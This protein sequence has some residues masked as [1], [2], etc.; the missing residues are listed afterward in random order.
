MAEPISL[1]RLA[2]I[3]MVAAPVAGVVWETTLSVERVSAASGR[4]LNTSTWWAL[5]TEGGWEDA[6][7]APALRGGDWVLVDRWNLFHAAG[8]AQKSTPRGS[9][10][11]FHSPAQREGSLLTARVGAF[12]GEWTRYGVVPRG[13][14]MVTQGVSVARGL[15]V[16]RAVG[17]VWPPSRW[18]RVPL[19]N[20]M[21]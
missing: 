15:V 14:V 8:P 4:V 5:G 16:G 11:A 2:R 9:L 12:E 7:P 13:H 18:G 19:G 17:V 3:L 6:A 20:S 21:S 10:V 1:G